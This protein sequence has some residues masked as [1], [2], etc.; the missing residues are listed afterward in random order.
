MA[1]FLKKLPATKVIDGKTYTWWAIAQN[2]TIAQEQADR[3]K[4]GSP[5]GSYRILPWPTNVST[6]NYGEGPGFGPRYVV[7]GTSKNSLRKF[8]SR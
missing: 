1:K 4:A 7:W 2:K 5:K 8:C 6:E 3:F